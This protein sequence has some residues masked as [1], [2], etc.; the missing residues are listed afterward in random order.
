MSG[1]GGGVV[2]I[3]P[4]STYQYVIILLAEV[5]CFSNINKLLCIF[6]CGMG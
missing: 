5:L 1:G 2:D 6:H 3:I 4:V